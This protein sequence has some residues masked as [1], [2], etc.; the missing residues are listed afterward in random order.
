VHNAHRTMQSKWLQEIVHTNPAWLNPV[1]A[2]RL[3][4]AEGDWIEVTSYRPRDSQVPYDDGSVVGTLKTRVHLAEGVHPEVIA[5][6]HN[7]GRWVGGP[8]ASRHGVGVPEPFPGFG[9]LPTPAAGQPWWAGEVSVAQNNLLPIYPDP[10]SG[11]QAY[12]DTIVRVRK[13]HT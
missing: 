3:G 6:S 13:L 4:L 5:I 7:H 10:R 2:G 9:T 12:H 8:I 1:T 11:Q